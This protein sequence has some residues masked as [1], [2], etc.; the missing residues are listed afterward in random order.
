MQEIPSGYAFVSLLGFMVTAIS[1]IIA[2]AAGLAK[3]YRIVI[4]VTLTGLMGL[5]L[6]WVSVTGTDEIKIALFIIG[7]ASASYAA[8]KDWLRTVYDLYTL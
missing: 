6:L 4:F 7:V 2:I 5:I 8:P 3:K 1:L